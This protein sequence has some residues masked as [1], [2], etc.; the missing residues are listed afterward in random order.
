MLLCT[1]QQSL[2]K[3]IKINLYQLIQVSIFVVFQGLKTNLEKDPKVSGLEKVVFLL[4]FLSFI[5]HLLFS[6]LAPAIAKS[7][8]WLLL[9]SQSWPTLCNPMDCSPPGYIL[10]MR[11]S[12][13]EYRNGF[14]VPSPGDPPNPWIKPASLHRRQILYPWA[15]WETH[16]T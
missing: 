10:S 11:F 14:P 16:F 7:I 5:V 13:Q 8:I 9:F 12:Q 3:I 1:S 2:I 15:I 6:Y 4:F